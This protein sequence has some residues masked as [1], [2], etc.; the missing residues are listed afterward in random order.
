MTYKKLLWFTL[1]ELIVVIT[2]IG[3]LS[4]VGFV[5]Y[6]NYLTGARDSNRYSQMTKLSDSLQVYATDKSLPLPDDYIEITA[7]WASNVIAYQGYV[8][9]DVLETI[10]YTNWWRDPKDDSFYTYYLTKDRKSLQLMA[11]MEEWV[12]SNIQLKNQKTIYAADYSS[13]FP[14]TYGSKLWVFVSWETASLNTPVQEIS[15]IKS[16]G[17]LDIINT[18]TILTALFQD[19]KSSI[20]WTWSTIKILESV[21]QEGWFKDSLV[22]WYDMESSNNNNLTDLS[23]NWNNALRIWTQVLPWNT[24]WVFWKAS[25]FEWL[26]GWFK[27]DNTSIL[28]SNKFSISLWQKTNSIQLNYGSIINQWFCTS[29]TCDDN[30]GNDWWLWNAVNGGKGT[31]NMIFW[32]WSTSTLYSQNNLY[33]DD[34]WHN[35][36]IVKSWRELLLYVDWVLRDSASSKNQTEINSNLPLYIWTSWH[37]TTTLDSTSYIDELRIF[38][39]SLDVDEIKKIYLTWLK[40]I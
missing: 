5:S 13:R 8:W 15:T 28:K 25:K 30:W 24:T 12:A 1:V 29:T 26:I 21:I 3:I 27:L 19:T 7:S 31:I 10:D 36:V 6:S 37:T 23:W 2:I 16:S 14:K 35:I 38:N 18:N 20:T 17:Y 40:K 22:V 33:S 9:T 32:T 39:T 34:V 4:T 11:L